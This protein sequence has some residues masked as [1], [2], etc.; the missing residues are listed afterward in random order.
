MEL[1]TCQLVSSWNGLLL[2]WTMHWLMFSFLLNRIVW[3][4]NSSVACAS[5]TTCLKEECS[6]RKTFLQ[7]SYKPTVP[8][9]F[10]AAILNVFV[11]GK[12]V[13][14]L[15][16]SYEKQ[17]YVVKPLLCHRNNLWKPGWAMGNYTSDCLGVNRTL[18]FHHWQRNVKIDW[19]V[20]NH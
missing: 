3:A 20:A 10:I 4:W 18:P 19:Q 16:L 8:L 13:R 17:W 15:L 6:V 11:K 14:W 7:L 1:Q 2:L 9:L 5:I 12:P